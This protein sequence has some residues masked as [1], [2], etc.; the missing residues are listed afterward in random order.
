MY[1]WW[2]LGVPLAGVVIVASVGFPR[3][4]RGRAYAISC[5]LFVLGM[6]TIAPRLFV[7]RSGLE[8]LRF[9]HA[10]EVL[11]ARGR[12]GEKILL[13][14]IG[15]IGYRVPMRVVDEVGLVSPWVAER[16]RQGPG[17]YV[18]VVE[19]ERPD[20]L[21]VRRGVLRTGGGYVGIGNPFR[22]LEERDSLVARYSVV[23]PGDRG[24]G[25][26]AIVVLRC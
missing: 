7:R 23:D 17:W 10:A 14:P 18:D 6:W 21:A 8:W 24:S 4:I 11:S 20:W 12:P 22:S 5:A 19:R 25:D 1:L 2:D 9:G 3:V 15:I 16:R 13:E 26:N